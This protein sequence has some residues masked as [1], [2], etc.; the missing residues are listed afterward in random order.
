MIRYSEHH[1]WIDITSRVASPAASLKPFVMS[2]KQEAAKN[3]TDF[4]QFVIREMIFS[5]LINLM[6]WMQKYK[7]LN[8]QTKCGGI[9]RQR[10]ES[11]FGPSSE[12]WRCNENNTSNWIQLKK[13]RKKERIARICFRLNKK[14]YWIARLGITYLH[15]FK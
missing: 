2:W 7:K 14:L 15:A 3:E 1:L 9:E 11:Q 5:W 10:K 8:S 13:N 4:I 12:C 6:K